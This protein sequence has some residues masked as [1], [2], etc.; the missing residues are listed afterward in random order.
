MR[1]NM[2][3]RIN[4]SMPK[5][6]NENNKFGSFETLGIFQNT[7]NSKGSDVTLYAYAHTHAH[8][9]VAILVYSGVRIVYV[10]GI[11]KSCCSLVRKCVIFD[12]LNVQKINEALR[13]VCA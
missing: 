11:W 2:G 1:I 13:T 9:T 12:L 4:M 8:N 6:K 10:F 5:D 3:M 7:C